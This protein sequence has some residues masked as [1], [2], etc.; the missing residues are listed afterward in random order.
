[1]YQL[2][3]GKKQLNM[4]ITLLLVGCGL[5]I[6]FPLLFPYLEQ[7]I[8]IIDELLVLVFVV[9]VL[10]HIYT[11]RI[12]VP[13]FVISVSIILLFLISIT[14][15]FYRGG[16]ISA[17]QIFTHLKFFIVFYLIHSA[18]KGNYKLG[19]FHV[20]A[21][22]SVLGLFVNLFLPNYFDL[23][24]GEKYRFLAGIPRVVGFQG[25]PNNMAYCV[26]LLQ[27][28]YGFYIIQGKSKSKMFY[29]VLL[30]ICT[31]LIS[32]LAGSRASLIFYPV[33]LYFTLKDYFKI[34][35]KSIIYLSLLLI[36]FIGVFVALSDSFID[37]TSKNLMSVGSKDAVEYYNPRS[38]LYFY[39]FMLFIDFF[40]LG[41]G[42]GTFGST[43]SQGSEVYKMLG[44]DQMNWV[45]TTN[46]LFDSNLACIAGEFGLVGIVLFALLGL[47]FYRW[48]IGRYESKYD[49]RRFLVIYVFLIFLAT[50]GNVFMNGIYALMFSYALTLPSI[51][52]N[53]V[54]SDAPKNAPV[55]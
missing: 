29:Y 4:L 6:L 49:R 34:N 1:M 53:E 25:K 30:T 2:L 23:S 55:Q 8:T 37:V 31:I 26:I 54:E 45:V 28:I 39:G 35:L 16:V 10:Y 33:I 36:I 21:A 22:L 38:F 20:I 41:T 11:G 48:G 46:G 9:L 12:P 42:S 47:Y 43:Y 40:P 24:E 52:N 18:T 7:V 14:S 19:Y 3:I 50:K 44:I 5:I 15:P 32:V 27:I 17:I 13:A 51:L